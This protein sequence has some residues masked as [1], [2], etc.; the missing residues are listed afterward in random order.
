LKARKAFGRPEIAE[1]IKHVLF[2]DSWYYRIDESERASLMESWKKVLEELSDVN[3]PE[4]LDFVR[5][6]IQV[7]LRRMEGRA[8]PSDFISLAN[9][10]A[11][12]WLSERKPYGLEEIIER[13]WGAAG[14]IDVGVR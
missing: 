7:G 11:K 1:R 13:F 4:D 10:Y 6:C 12:L 2:A 9:S 14:R 8:T 3:L 5:K